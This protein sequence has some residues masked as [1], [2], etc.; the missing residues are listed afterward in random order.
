M[1]SLEKNEL[2]FGKRARHYRG[3]SDSRFAIRIINYMDVREL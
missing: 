1:N 2:F 3:C